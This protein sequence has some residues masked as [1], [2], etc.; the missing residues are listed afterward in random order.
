MKTRQLVLALALA[1]AG[2]SRAAGPDTEV[3]EFYNVALGHYFIT[4]SARDVRLIEDGAAGAGW[5][6]TGRTFQAWSDAS[7]APAGATPVCRFYSPGANSHFFTAKPSECEV[8]KAQEAA[9]RAT[10]ANPKGWTF[11][12][13]G[14]AIEV[15]QGGQCPAGT[16]AIQRFY[17]HGFESGEGANHRYVDDAGAVELMKQSG[18]NAEGTAFRAGACWR[19]VPLVTGNS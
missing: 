17:N 4:A 13:T 3:V 14:F 16:E 11:E 1:A 10:T 18:W 15:P 6:K 7:L 12:G 5:V 8:L 19:V 9:E 2:T